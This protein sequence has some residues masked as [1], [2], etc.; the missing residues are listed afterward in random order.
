MQEMK[1]LVG[2]GFIASVGGWGRPEY[3]ALYAGRPL[4]PFTGRFLE[5]RQSAKRPA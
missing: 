4:P 3:R 2:T 5:E 1:D